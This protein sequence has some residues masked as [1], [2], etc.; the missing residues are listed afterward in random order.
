[1]DDKFLFMVDDLIEIIT[2]EYPET[3]DRFIA[4]LKVREY[5]ET[6]Y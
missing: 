6:H 4:A 5:I 2:S 3:D 1:M